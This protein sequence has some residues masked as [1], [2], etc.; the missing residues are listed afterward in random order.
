ML[1]SMQGSDVWDE[2]K[3]ANDYNE[4]PTFSSEDGGTIKAY[5][6]YIQTQS[7][8]FIDI[9]PTDI[10]QDTIKAA[11][12]NMTLDY[13]SF[14]DI[15]EGSDKFYK[16]AQT[17]LKRAKETQMGGKVFSGFDFGKEIGGEITEVT[18]RNGNKEE[19]QEKM[20]G[21]NTPRSFVCL[22]KISSSRPS[23]PCWP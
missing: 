18:D 20:N 23:G 10:N 15:F 6:N 3:G 17:F 21:V 13:M 11:I 19:K 4:M 22:G 8:E 9:L 16:D 1:T 5:D 7:Q 2:S 12:Y 14:D